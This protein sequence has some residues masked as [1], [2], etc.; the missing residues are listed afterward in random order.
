MVRRK[1]RLHRQAKKTGKW[2]NYRH[3]QR[4]C[5]R[6]FR[7]AEWTCVN[8]TIQDGLENNNSKPFWRYLKAKQ[9]DNIGV[10]PLKRKGQL[11]SD[12]RSKTDI[13]VN[14][15][16]SVFTR[17]SS[18]SMPSVG[19]L[20]DTSIGEL[21]ITE[22]GVLKLLRNIQTS[23]APGP[24][25]IPNRVLKEC[26][27]QLAPSITITFQKSVDSGCLPKDWLNTNI[28]PVFKKED[29]H[30][31][32]KYRPLSLTSV[33]SKLLEHILCRHM[34]KHFERH[35]ILTSLNHGFRAGYSCETQL[36]VTIE[37]LNTSFDR[38]T[39]TDIAILDFSKAFDTVRHNKLLHKL[40]EYGIRGNLHTWI[41][42]FLC[43]RHMK[44]VV[45]GES[46][47]EVTVDSGVPQGTVFTTCS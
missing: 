17:D 16:S 23:K 5:K 14:Q 47:N 26:A 46:S 43:N 45:E 1:T 7:R 19:K 29:R 32:E 31:P 8:N 18:S 40:Q 21:K 38:G 39:Q 44:V 12:S 28:A 4:E 20:C 11:L 10:S 24:D 34:L 9:Q 37:D 3:F 13:L 27:T 42:S 6:A 22:E 33:L 2:E 35:N 25:S 41:Q 36:A 30:L 15:F